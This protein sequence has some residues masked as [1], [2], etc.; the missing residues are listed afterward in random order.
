MNAKYEGGDTMD[1]EAIIIFMLVA[2]ILGILVG[3]SMT[4]PTARL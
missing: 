3:V 4:R 2:F 1:V